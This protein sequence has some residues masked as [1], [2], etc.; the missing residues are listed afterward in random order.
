MCLETTNI[1]GLSNWNWEGDHIM[2]ECIVP[3]SRPVVGFPAKR[4]YD[5]S[6]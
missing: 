2:H 3:S 5:M 6:R 1:K 4:K